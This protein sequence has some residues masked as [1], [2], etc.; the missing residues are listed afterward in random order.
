MLESGRHSIFS[1]VPKSSREFVERRY[2]TRGTHGCKYDDNT[3]LT[4]HHSLRTGYVYRSV[5]LQNQMDS[6]CSVSIANNVLSLLQQISRIEPDSRSNFKIFGQPT[7]KYMIRVDSAH[8]VGTVLRSH[9]L[10]RSSDTSKSHHSDQE[11]IAIFF[12][13]HF[14]KTG[15]NSRVRI[16]TDLST[17][18]CRSD[19][20]R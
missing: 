13:L 19:R 11:K 1:L 5:T 7:G 2:E 12:C 4:N 16:E 3:Q 15:T 9:T 14:S 17:E 10:F 8:S 6:A 18:D 20:R